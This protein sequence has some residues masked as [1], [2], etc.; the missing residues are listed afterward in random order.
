[1]REHMLETDKEQVQDVVRSL[2]V[3]LERFSLLIPNTLVAE[4]T[5]GKHHI[6]ISIIPEWVIA[7][8]DWRGRTV[9]LVSYELLLGRASPQTGEHTKT[10]ILNTL[11]KDQA[12]PFIGL[13]TQGV[14]RPLSVKDGMLDRIEKESEGDNTAALCHTSIRGEPSII[15]D[16]DMLEKMILS[17]GIIK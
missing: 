8:F 3:P 9:P 6:P 10:I 13:I 5:P 11:N 2:I 1:M 17:A 15:P 4:V 14:P 16:I 7:M 12:L